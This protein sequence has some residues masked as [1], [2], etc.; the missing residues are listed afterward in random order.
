MWQWISQVKHFSSFLALCF[1]KGNLP[2]LYNPAGC[3]W[4]QTSHYYTGCSCQL[5]SREKGSI[6]VLTQGYCYSFCYSILVPAH[7]ASSKLQMSERTGLPLPHS[8]SYREA[9]CATNVLY[10][11]C[12][13]LSYSLCEMYQS[14]VSFTLF[15]SIFVYSNQFHK[16]GRP[17][18]S[19]WTA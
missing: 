19:W 1:R 2:S 8:S 13:F 4:G 16:A 3:W 17:E 6:S 12:V 11:F 14:V 5:K 10:S 15:I 18:L 9:E 7:T